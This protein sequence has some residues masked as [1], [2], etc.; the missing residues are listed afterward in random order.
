MSRQATTP[1]ARTIALL[2]RQ[3]D[4]SS[5]NDLLRDLA[6]ARVVARG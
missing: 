5:C 6:L 2:G 1:K 3:P 4:N